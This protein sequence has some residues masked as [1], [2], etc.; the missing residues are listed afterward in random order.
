MTYETILDNQWG[1][2]FHNQ[3]HNYVYHIIKKDTNGTDIQ[4]LLNTGLEAL[5]KHKSEKWISDDRLNGPV[6]PEDIEFSLTDWGPRAA[7]AGWK[8]WALVVPEEIAGRATMV[9]VVKA[10]LELGV[11][12]RVFTD[13]AKGREWL[14]NKPQDA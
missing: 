10:Y 1:T 5:I 7:S 14:L 11:H 4:H 6:L 2:V 3:T 12:V 9:A 8:Y 13:V